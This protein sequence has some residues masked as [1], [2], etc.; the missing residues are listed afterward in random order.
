MA[1]DENRPSAAEY[2][3][4]EHMATDPRFRAEVENVP[5]WWMNQDTE[6]V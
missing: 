6:E 3:Y 2:D 4:Y 1:Y 5:D